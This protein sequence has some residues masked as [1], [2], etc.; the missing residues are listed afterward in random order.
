MELNFVKVNPCENTTVYITDSVKRSLHTQIAN[1]IM[2]Y[3]NLHAEQV[4]F[5][6]KCSTEN[7]KA[8]AKLQMMGGEFCGN[9]CRGFAAVI[10][11]NLNITKKKQIY[12][13]AS[14][15]NE[16][17]LCEV[18][19]LNEKEYFV[20]MKLPDILNISEIEIY[21]DEINLKGYMIDFGG[22]CHCVFCVESINSDKSYIEKLLKLLPYTNYDAFGIMQYNPITNQLL[23]VVYVKGTNSLFFERSCG[24]GTS[25]VGVTM[26]IIEK[27][28]QNLKVKQ[29]GG[30]L[31][32]STQYINGKVENIVLGGIVKI[33]SKG[34][35]YV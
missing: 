34:A 31:T 29:D 3:G 2:E 8:L 18:T 25:A 10:A 1:S 20:S 23:P 13:E 11:D 27:Q 26:A 21:K 16:T 12:I 19:P 28:N 14:G 24:S 7:P 32:I 30:I 22:I 6:E 4:G 33:V 15:T 17:L 5:F 35:V 9:A